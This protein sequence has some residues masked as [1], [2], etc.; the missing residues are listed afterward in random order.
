MPLSRASPEGYSGQDSFQASGQHVPGSKLQA[1]LT[2][3]R[4]SMKL[5]PAPRCAHHAAQGAPIRDPVPPVSLLPCGSAA[6]LSKGPQQLATPK[7]RSNLLQ[8]S[9]I[10]AALRFHSRSRARGPVFCRPPSRERSALFRSI[11]CEQRLAFCLCRPTGGLRPLPR[12]QHR[13]PVPS[14]L[15]WPLALNSFPGGPPWVGPALS[16]PSPSTASWAGAAGCDRQTA[17]AR[18]H[19]PPAT[20]WRRGPR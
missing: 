15:S 6:P 13:L 10:R 2:D 5:V 8:F 7:P 9:A 14:R 17:L 19:V 11:Q 20:R 4:L 16:P 18:L 12:A 1:A 3:Q